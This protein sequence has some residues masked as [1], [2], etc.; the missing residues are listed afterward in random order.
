MLTYADV[1]HNKLAPPLV[2]LGGGRGGERCWGGEGRGGGAERDACEWRG[3]GAGRVGGGGEGTNGALGPGLGG[4][5]GMVLSIAM[6]YMEG[7][8]LA[9][10]IEEFGP[11]PE[12]VV[13]GYARQV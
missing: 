12:A 5:G 7:G 6:E 4:G 1:W 9:K 2:E 13:A 8:S 10:V 3:G 11:L